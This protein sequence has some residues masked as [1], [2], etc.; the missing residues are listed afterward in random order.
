MDGRKISQLWEI[1]TSAVPQTGMGSE[2]I[3]CSTATTSQ[4]MYIKICPPN[5]STSVDPKKQ[6]QNHF[7]DKH[8]KIN[9]TLLKISSG[10]KKYL[11]AQRNHHK[12]E[13]CAYLTMEN[14]NT[15]SKTIWK[16]IK[17]C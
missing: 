4:E 8:I 11:I 3:L 9:T 2:F 15:W 17:Y 1:K 12:R 13:Q 5:F 7:N 14:I 10:L 16:G 6:I